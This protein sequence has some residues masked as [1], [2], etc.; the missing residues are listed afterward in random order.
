M[1]VRGGLSPSRLRLIPTFVTPR[2]VQPH[3]ERRRRICF[4]GR[5]EPIKGIE[6]LLDAMEL[7]RRDGDAARDVELV[8]AGDTST[9]TGE[10]IRARLQARPI[11]GVDLRGQLEHGAVIELLQSS[12]ASVVP[13]LWYE[14]LP[15]A[16]LESLSCGTPVIASDI[17]S[18]HDI[19]G[20]TGAGVLFRPGDPAALAEGIRSA[21]TEPSGE[22]MTER[23]VA[24][25]RERHDP[26]RHVDDLIDLFE[27]VRRGDRGR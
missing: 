13:S 8:L 11:P 12:L 27:E 24:L 16:L 10:A 26:G 4:I 23:A 9:P 17:G 22:Q 14:N 25:A 2:P 1:M 15:N 18:L 21:L 20:G 6:V 7:L 5:F 3:A 19:L